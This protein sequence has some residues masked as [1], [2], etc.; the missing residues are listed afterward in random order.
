[1]KIT[2]VIKQKGS[3]TDKAIARPGLGSSK[4]NKIEA[5]SIISLDTILAEKDE[6]KNAEEKQRQKIN[7]IKAKVNKAN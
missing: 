3:D 1:M 5:P 6:V 7:R 2:K 4:E